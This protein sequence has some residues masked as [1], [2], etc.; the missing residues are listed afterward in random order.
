MIQRTDDHNKEL[1]PSEDNLFLMIVVI[2]GGPAGRY[3]AMRLAGSGRDVVLVDRRPDGLGG[4]C[5]HQGCMVICALNDVARTIEHL[6]V[7][8]RSGIINPLPVLDFSTLVRRMQTIIR[9]I[10]GVIDTETRDAGVKVVIG[11]AAVHGRRVTINGE[12]VEAESIIIATGSRPKNPNIPGNELTGVYTAHSI[13]NLTS[14]PTRMV[15]IGGGSIA[16]EFA[17]LFSVFGSEVTILA[18]STLLRSFPEP[19]VREAR[20][21]LL[22]VQIC[23]RA[24]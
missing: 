4:Q 9:T 23:E 24:S 10:A 8:S 11:E 5:L 20:R 15:I 13:L 1:S 18:R 22:R 21:D 16:T 19:L 6:E 3:A 17:Y 7:M 12:T 2:G 14:L